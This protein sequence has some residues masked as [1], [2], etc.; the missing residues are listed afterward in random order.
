VLPF[1]QIW[2]VDF[3]F[4]SEPGERPIPVCVVANEI[5]TGKVLKVWLKDENLEKPPY[6]VDDAT[7]LIAYYGSAEWACHLVLG[8]PLP[9]NTVDLFAEYRVLTNGLL[10]IRSGLINACSYFGILTTSDSF[11]EGMRARIMQGPPYTEEEKSLIMD[12]CESDVIAT[13]ELFNKMQDIIDIP[14]ALYRGQYMECV[15]RMEHAG[16]PIDVVILE[17]LKLHWERIKERLIEETD[18][19]F[20]VYEETTF[21][22]SRFEEY[23]IKNEIPWPK[24]E[25]GNLKLDDNSFKDM[26]KAYPQLQALRDLRYILGQLKLNELPVGRDG[27]NRCLLSP[28]RTKTGRNAPS[29]SK[30]IF[31]PAVWL[32]SLIKP[33]P[34]KVLLYVDYS[35]QEFYIAAVLSGDEAM[36]EA[37][38]TGDPY[39]AFAKQAGAVPQDA[40]KQTHRAERDAFK[41]CSLGVQ[42]GMMSNSLACQ[43]GK[44]PAHAKELIQHHKRVYRRYWGWVEEVFNS[45]LISRRITTCYG[46]SY[47][48]L[49]N[50]AKEERTIKNFPTQATG[51]EILRVAC[52]LLA[53]KGF[54]VV[55]PIHDALLIECGETDLKLVGAEVQK[56]MGDASEHVL[57]KGH[58]IRTDVEI[59]KYPDRYSD[60]RG[61]E[62]WK[63]IIQ[64]MHEIEVE[65]TV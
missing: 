53:D 54:N 38:E 33:G 1:E 9:K 36:I 28:F 4:I 34:G 47:Q 22:I 58:R 43:L 25:K 63:Q 41:V 17:K 27:R 37:Y 55:A 18:K 32:R 39:L 3:E 7:L 31:G 11:K 19:D 35:Q 40:T 5:K 44:T 26:S 52:I 46:W 57:G 59:I 20:R 16:V 12:Y 29:T 24:T 48:I 50:D 62:T 64:I 21:K 51:A 8:W 2:A 56:L 60:P 6:P 65:N 14:R 45:T 13:A 42:Y 61:K 30:F 15:A 10:G 49:G 23:L